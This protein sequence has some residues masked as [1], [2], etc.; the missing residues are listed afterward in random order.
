MKYHEEYRA[1]KKALGITNKDIAAVTGHT[2]ATV[3]QATREGAEF[4]R[5]LKLSVL[6]YK[7]VLKATLAKIDKP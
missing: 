1:M 5:W 6:I 3:K 2:P 7:N 4:P